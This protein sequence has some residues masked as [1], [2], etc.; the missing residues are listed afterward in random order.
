MNK[1]I[2][3][4]CEISKSERTITVNY[5][6]DE[7]LNEYLYIKGFHSPC[8]GCNSECPIFKNLKQSFTIPKHL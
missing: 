7:N 3:D 5:L 2:T 4:Y 1:E 6:E 8:P